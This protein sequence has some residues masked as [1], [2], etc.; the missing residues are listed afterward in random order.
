DRPAVAAAMR[1]TLQTLNPRRI[2]YRLLSG[3]EREER[4]IETFATAV[5]EPGKTPTLLGLCRD[6]THRA[7][8]HHELRV[9]AREQEALARIGEQALRETNLQKLFDESVA[10]IAQLL[11][12]ELVKILELV[13][14]DAELLLRSGT[15]W[16][17]G[18][19]GTAYISTGRHTHAGFTLASG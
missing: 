10:S 13:P 2:T 8:V 14:G 17:A 9:R 6:V 11:D 12:V 15:G 4:W 3:P 7:K 19:V 5:I 16:K 18:L 1:E